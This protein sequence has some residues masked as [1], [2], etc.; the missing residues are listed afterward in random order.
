[1]PQAY[2]YVRFS[3]PEQAKGDSHRRQIEAAE[4]WARERGL[5]LDERLIDQGVSAY[6]G[7]HA[8]VGA[9]GA[10][11]DAVRSGQVE[12][13][14]TLIVESLDRLS[15]QQILDA[16]AQFTGIISAGIRIV[17]LSDGA[18]YT[19]ETVNNDF[20]RLIISLTIMSR[21]HEESATKAARL[22]AAWSNK[23]N[24]ARDEGRPLTARAPGWLRLRPDR[25]GYDVDEDRAE[26]VRRVFRDTA[27]GVG[28]FA[29]TARLNSENVPTFARA[30]RG[31]PGK[32][33]QW[34]SSA[35][36]KILDSQ[37]VLGW[38]Q[39]HRK[40][41]EG[42]RVPEGDPVR[43]YPAVV[44]E[45]LYWQAQAARQSR[46]G[47]GG[48]R[49]EFVNTLS[50]LCRCAECGGPVALVNK[51]TG[52]KSGGRYFM[53]SAARRAAGC[54]NRRAWRWDHVEAAVLGR[55]TRLDLTRVLPGE[56]DEADQNAARVAA[57]ETE[58]ADVE[59]RKTRWADA[60]EEG[61]DDAL[62]RMRSYSARAKQV[63]ADLAVAKAAAEQA[64]ATRAPLAAR[65]AAVAA[66]GAA[67]EGAAGA[68]E[69]ALRL[70]LS[71]ELRRV[72]ERVEF[73]KQEVALVWGRDAAPARES[74]FAVPGA[75]ARIVVLSRDPEAFGGE[76]DDENDDIDAD[77][78]QVRRP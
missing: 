22:S 69:H 44:S 17:T 40:T 43:L 46:R 21:A 7:R 49:S 32:P 66:L 78:F 55:A 68:D 27:A 37:S 1:M 15:R 31:N 42:R 24:K 73:S 74:A 13:G 51:G 36:A 62:D 67:L 61:D 23:R 65:Q 56:P 11:L 29:L 75:T 50:G 34:Y 72:V 28:Q 38:Y 52:P 18:E 26:V 48:P 41:A 45:D 5:V 9:L 39:P 57:L 19:R 16:L 30:I 58:L 71:Q 53:C 12:P 60:Y 25:N 59:R 47:T 77:G 6:R 54:T 4:A 63:S 3:R 20:G 10:F 33:G 70:K 8:A 35:V 64:K 14:S 2:S 76:M